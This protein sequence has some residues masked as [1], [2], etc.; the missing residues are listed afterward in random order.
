MG[1]AHANDLSLEVRPVLILN[2]THTY[3]SSLSIVY[4]S[5]PLV[6]LARARGGQQGV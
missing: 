3:L 6:L 5:Y 2:S 1:V 4:D